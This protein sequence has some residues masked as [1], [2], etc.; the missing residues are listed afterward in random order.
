M[1]AWALPLF[2]VLGLAGAGRGLAEERITSFVSDVRVQANGDLDVVETIALESEGETIQRGI[3]RDFPTRYRTE[4]GR[5]VE[6][7]FTVVSVERD[8]RTEPFKLMRMSNGQRVRI[9]DP[10]RLLDPGAHVYSI[11]YRTTRQLGFFGDFD[12]LYWNATGTG[13]TFPIEQAEARITLPTAARFGKRAVYTGAQGDTGKNAEVVSERPGQIVFHTTQRLEAQ[14]G[15]TVAAAWP[16]GVVAEPSQGQRLG[17]FLR[18]QGGLLLAWAGVV[19]IAA[20]MARAVWRARRNPDPWPIVPLFSPPDGLSAAAVR[21]I[22]KGKFDDRAF[23]AAI[24]DVAVRGHL[25]IVDKVKKGSFGKPVR[26][27]LKTVGKPPLPP[28][29]AAM[30]RELFKGR[31]SLQ[32]SQGNHRTLMDAR[33]DLDRGLDRAYGE[34]RYNSDAAGKANRGWLALAGLLLSLAV[35]LV[36]LN[37]PHAAPLTLGAVAVGI[38]GEV[39]RRWLKR[40]RAGPLSAKSGKR[41]LSFIGTG[42]AVLATWHAGALLVFLGFAAGDPVPMLV[43]LL[44]LPIVIV[45]KMNLR[46][47]TAEGWPLRARIAGFR[48]YLSVAEEDRLERLNPPEK[49]AELFEKYLPYA[50]ALKVETRWAKRFARVLAQAQMDPEKDWYDGDQRAFSRPAAFATSMGSSLVATIASAS[51]PPGSSGGGS[52]SSSSSGSSGG[53]SSGGGGGGGGG[54]GW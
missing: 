2:L 8:G 41:T 9:G 39:A 20:Y 10:D 17:W 4:R 22:W 25:R 12:E 3:Q 38:G 50:I 11:R 29:E 13:W 14:E 33:M 5:L 42:I 34:D 46:G 45:A 52:S 1:R 15:L 32:L 43:A 53:G 16:K 44:A 28:A 19:A 21:Y 24:V 40:L 31:A 54:S 49:T 23:T 36:L 51:T 27:L 35:L 26:R 48:H 30:V 7:G 6:V 18:E 37:A 47:P